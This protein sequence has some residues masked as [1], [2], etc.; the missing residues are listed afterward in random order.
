VAP[1]VPQHVADFLDRFGVEHTEIH[2]AE[3][4]QVASRHNYVFASESAPPR[5]RVVPVVEPTKKAPAN[6]EAAFHDAMLEIYE[7]AKAECKYYATRF[8]QMVVERGGLQTARYLLHAP[9][10]S[11]G[12]TAL[13]EC[14]RLDLTVEAYVLKPEWRELFTEEEIKVA[15]KRLSELGYTPS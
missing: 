10:L 13:W 14:K 9:G 6:R 7:R 3:F 12:F 15:T 1:V 2:E 8:L 5:A 4:R 11:D